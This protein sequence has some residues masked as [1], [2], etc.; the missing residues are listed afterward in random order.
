LV[1]Y[2]IIYHSI[3]NISLFHHYNPT[4][5]ARRSPKKSGWNAI[6]HHLS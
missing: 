3:S 4:L 2:R 1:R 6:H 5:F